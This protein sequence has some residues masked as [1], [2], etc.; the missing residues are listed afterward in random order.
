MFVWE[1]VKSVL[2][3][4]SCQWVCQWA[5]SLKSLVCMLQVTFSVWYTL[6]M[7]TFCLM[8]SWINSKFCHNRLK[9]KSLDHRK[10]CDTAETIFSLILMKH[11]LIV[12]LYL[13]KLQIL[14]TTNQKGGALGLM[15]FFVFHSLSTIYVIVGKRNLLNVWKS[16]QTNL[17]QTTLIFGVKDIVE[18]IM[19]KSF[20]NPLLHT[21]SFWRINN[22]Q[23]LKTVWEKK[24]LLIMSNFLF[25][26]NAFYEIR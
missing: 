17:Y 26:H 20:V 24:K 14:V 21:Y 22:R 12:C 5:K 8:I 1:R 2:F 15:A 4:W 10:S 25:S 3:L 11:D 16:C 19:A 23:L 18:T 9:S 7:V 13:W 6:E